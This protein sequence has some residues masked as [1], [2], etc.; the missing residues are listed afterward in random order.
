MG[1][2]PPERRAM[3]PPRKLSDGNGVGK[4][5]PR[6]TAPLG[7]PAMEG[8][9]LALG[10]G[11][12]DER[13]AVLPPRKLSARSGVSPTSKGPPPSSIRALDRGLGSSREPGPSNEQRGPYCH[14]GNTL[15]ARTCV[16]LMRRGLALSCWCFRG[17]LKTTPRGVF[18][19]PRVFLSVSARSLEPWRRFHRARDVGW[20]SSP[21][22]AP[23]LLSCVF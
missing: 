10:R 9:A 19:S 11:L 5:S 13:R 16:P 8:P 2:R 23:K 7:A 3:L 12:P 4:T 17:P 1:R 18:R 14:S 22:L 15:R 20:I 6:R 21:A